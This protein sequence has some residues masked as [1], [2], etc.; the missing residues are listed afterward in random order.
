M[1]ISVL[2]ST[3]A[4]DI[5]NAQVLDAVPQ[6]IK[7]VVEVGT[8]SGALAREIL[9]K[10]PD[11]EYVGVEISEQYRLAAQSWCTR[12]YLENFEHASEKLIAEL[13]DTDIV[14]FAD[15]L[16]HFIDPWSALSR[17]RE[18]LP[19]RGRVIASI[20]NVQHWSMHYRL[21]A[22]DFRYAETGLLDRTHLR[23]FTR[24]TMIEMFSSSGYHVANITPRI[25]AFPHQD[26][27][28]QKIAQVSQIFGLDSQLAVQDAAAFQFVVT[29]TVSMN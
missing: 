9:K 2:G 24:Q 21:M 27:M 13:N 19:E 8:G 17:M 14:I 6:G 3:P 10:F 12:V 16:E 7:K 29:A 25:F 23:F 5:H 22:G 28:L 15:V 18:A 1:A 20:P 4:T 11:I 26:V